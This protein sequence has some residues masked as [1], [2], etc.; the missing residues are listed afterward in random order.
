M[1]TR[2]EFLLEVLCEEIPANA[3]PGIREQLTRLFVDELAEAGFTG[4]DVQALST[5]RRLVVH[6]AGL[7]EVQPDR[8]EEVQGPS[9]RAAFAADGS[10]TPAAL[11]FAKGQGVSVD[12]LR[13]VAGPKGEVVAATRHVEGRPTPAVLGEITPRVFHALRF[14]K[15]MRWGRGEYSFVRPVHNVLGIFGRGGFD[16]VVECELFGLRSGS[17]SVGHRVFHPERFDLLGNTKVKD[18]KGYKDWLHGVSVMVD[19]AERR[20][21]LRD[22][23]RSLAADVGCTVREDGRLLDEVVEMV[24]CPRFARGSIAERFLELPEQV[25]VTTLRHHQKCFVLERDGRVAPYFLAVCDWKGEPSHEIVR[26]NEWVAG[27]RLADAAFFFAQDRKQPLGERRQAL[28]RVVFHQKLGSFATKAGLVGELAVRLAADAEL[29]LDA[30]LVRHTCALLKVDLTTAMVGEFPELQGVMGGIYA[31]G[32]GEPEPVCNA[33]AD[34]YQPAGLEGPLPRGPLAA[35]VGVADRLDTVAALFAV[36][37]VPSG[38]KDPFGLRRAALAAVRICAETPLTLDLRDAV[39]HAL[40]MRQLAKAKGSEGAAKLLEFVQ[41]R[42]RYYLTS[43][44]GISAGA[45]DAVI[46]ARWGVL[47]DDLARAHAVEA[48]RGE[49]VFAA[50][51]E[52]FKR[53][54]NMLAK[55]GGGAAGAKKLSEPAEKE[56]QRQLDKVDKEVMK[57]ESHSDHLASLRALATLAA[58]LDRLFTDVLVLCDDAELR[59]ARLALLARVEKLFLRLADVSRLSA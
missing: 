5:V 45:A 49:E 2:G 4:Y 14:P 37:E 47:P 19:L 21:W 18:F 55:A 25:V 38:S 54:R 36:G 56:L 31:Q 7:P 1:N 43:T 57:A 32:E 35:V 9:V 48:V 6:V 53:V 34:Q 15:T 20:E 42:V 46:G 26:G 29:G 28:E 33:I 58:P 41:E 3:L 16:T 12:S 17:T 51:A 8:D 27:A 11:G 13:V 23:M 52:A 44:V 24:E 39:R 50:L 22:R 10:P 40:E 59:N 30:E